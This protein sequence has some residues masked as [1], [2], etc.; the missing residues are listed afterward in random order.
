MIWRSS[1]APPATIMLTIAMLS[2]TVVATL[3]TVTLTRPNWIMMEQ[4]L[5][6]SLL[7]PL[8]HGE[9]IEQRVAH[10]LDLNPRNHT[11][12]YL[13][14]IRLRYRLLFRTTMTHH[15]KREKEEEVLGDAA[16]NV[17]GGLSTVVYHENDSEI[18]KDENDDDDGT[19]ATTTTLVPNRIV[20][21]VVRDVV[22]VDQLM[23][24][25]VVRSKNDPIVGNHTCYVLTNDDTLQNDLIQSRQKLIDVAHLDRIL[26]ISFLSVAVAIPG[27]LGLFFCLYL[28]LGLLKSVIVNCVRI[29]TKNQND[30]T[31]I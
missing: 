14:N 19:V 18:E 1:T 3:I 15:G 11:I 8:K 2:L 6:E 22:L 20:I 23:K 17:I 9:S 7:F 16:N 12:R 4:P 25:G 27:I 24:F 31:Q 10:S 28:M 13:Y 29:R 21:E 30:Y 5:E 26:E